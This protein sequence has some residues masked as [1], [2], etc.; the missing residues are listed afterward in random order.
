MGC[1]GL[2]TMLEWAWWSVLVIAA[3]GNVRCEVCGRDVVTGVCMR[4]GRRGGRRYFANGLEQGR[5]GWR[6]V[7]LRVTCKHIAG[8]DPSFLPQIRC[9]HPV[10]RSG[11]QLWRGF[12]LNKNT[13]PQPGNDFSCLAWD[14]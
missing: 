2:V 8:L 7:T 14:R 3:E 6:F 1:W 9:C 13:S 12:F 11:D 5:G 10:A 4:W